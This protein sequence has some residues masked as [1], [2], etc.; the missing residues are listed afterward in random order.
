MFNRR[1]KCIYTAIP[2]TATSSIGRAFRDAR[3]FQT[4]DNNLYIWEYSPNGLLGPLVGGK[5]AAY[6]Y[7]KKYILSKFNNLVDYK[8]FAFVRNPWDR[9][10]SAYLAMLSRNNLSQYPYFN[11]TPTKIELEKFI[12]SRVPMVLN[13]SPNNQDPERI[14]EGYKYSVWQFFIPQVSF[15]KDEEGK[16]PHTYVGRFENLQEDM[17]YIC[18]NILNHS[19]VKLSLLNHNVDRKPYKPLLY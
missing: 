3:C 5:H 16:I 17:D 4:W 1:A 8:S 2:K 10:I 11:P 9:I 19:T 14:I 6:L 15:L 18:K 13:L 12:E 7:D